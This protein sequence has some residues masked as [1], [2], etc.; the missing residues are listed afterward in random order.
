M[1]FFLAVIGLVS[2]LILF[3]PKS[4]LY[5]K[6]QEIL[7][8]KNIYI[9]SDIKESVTLNLTDAVVYV[10]GMDVATFKS[11]K[12]YPFLFFN[13]LK[14]KDIVFLQHYKL[15]LKVVYSVIEPFNVVI[16]GKSNF[17]TIK[18]KINILKRSGKIYIENITESEIKKI[19]KKDNKGYYYYAKF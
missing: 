5:F 17:G 9:N 12:I 2:A 18:G 10:N 19:L 6:L 4:N 11:C 7:K 3:M 14:L 8:E 1:R 13:M 16:S 15:N